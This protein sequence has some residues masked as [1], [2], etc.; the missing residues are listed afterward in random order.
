VLVRAVFFY[1]P[2]LL[3]RPYLDR[4]VVGRAGRARP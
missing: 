1:A 4:Y 3:G 2:L